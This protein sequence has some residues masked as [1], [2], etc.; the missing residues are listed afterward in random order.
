M[1][2]TMGALIKRLRQKKGLTQLELAQK[3]GVSQSVI[4]LYEVDKRNPKPGTLN[5]L[6]DVLE[7]D[8]NVFWALIMGDTS[9]IEDTTY[10]DSQEYLDTIQQF[11]QISNALEFLQSLNFSFDEKIVFEDIEYTRSLNGSNLCFF[12]NSN[13]PLE[14]TESE[15]FEII[16]STNH[17]PKHIVE[18]R[19]ADSI[20]N[21]EYH[22][23]L[24]WILNIVNLTRVIILQ[25]FHSITAP[26]PLLDDTEKIIE[27]HAEDIS[28]GTWQPTSLSAD[29]AKLKLYR[30]IYGDNV[31]DNL[32]KEE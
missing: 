4:G 6:A 28:N 2:E 18:I 14:Y 17:V 7:C 26:E 29:E 11:S 32:K 24:K 10:F 16:K 27:K 9:E 31:P 19:H 1:P 22:D 3:I 21:L 23:Y 12:S 30:A 25:Q 13:E 20:K 8:V 15:L 5:A